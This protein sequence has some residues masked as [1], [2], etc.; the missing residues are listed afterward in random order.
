M[1]PDN[2]NSSKFN[3]TTIPVDQAQ[4]DAIL[5]DEEL[6]GK[7]LREKGI[8]ENSELL[9]IGSGS[10]IA[11]GKKFA[12]NKE[13]AY[14]V[15]LVLVFFILGIFIVSPFLQL[16]LRMISDLINPKW[17]AGVS[18]IVDSYKFYDSYHDMINIINILV[19]MAAGFIYVY[20]LIRI[21]TEWKIICRQIPVTLKKLLPFL[22]FLL[23]DVGILLVTYARGPNEYDLTGHPY[24]GESIYSYILYPISYFFCVM[25]LSSEKFIDSFLDC[26]FDK[27][28][29]SLNLLF[30]WI[31]LLF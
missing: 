20:W 26:F 17:T 25:L 4:V 27:N 16:L 30:S 8:S 15:A 3:K 5:A 13:A 12:I 10:G 14:A 21:I 1:S 19:Y 18:E 11:T 9:G 31:M 23:F 22:L 2:N 6:M 29:I 28:E 7:I 24:M